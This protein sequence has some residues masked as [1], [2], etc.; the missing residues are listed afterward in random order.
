MN[1]I[2][3][4]LSM[5]IETRRTLHGILGRMDVLKSNAIV[6]T[7]SECILVA[8]E[9]EWMCLTLSQYAQTLQKVLGRKDQVLDH[10]GMDRHVSGPYQKVLAV[11]LEKVGDTNTQVAAIREPEYLLLHQLD[12][13]LHGVFCLGELSPRIVR[14]DPEL[15]SL[16]WHHICPKI[17][18]EEMVHHTN[19]HQSSRHHVTVHL[20]G[21]LG[22]K[23]FQGVNVHP[24]PKSIVMNSEAKDPQFNPQA[25]CENLGIQPQILSILVTDLMRVPVM[26]P[27]D[28]VQTD[29]SRLAIT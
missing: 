11:T 9:N 29:Q 1:P 8:P 5:I 3:G 26:T 12:P 19:A 13:G 17:A 2:P 14:M 10:Q 16:Q 22:K 25:Y 15:A 21:N 7:T 28:I 20:A 27:T 24:A 4:V 6:I 18:Q 23:I